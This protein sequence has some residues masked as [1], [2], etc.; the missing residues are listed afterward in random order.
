MSTNVRIGFVLA[1]TVLVGLAY[2]PAS[3]A[4]KKNNNSSSSD[5]KKDKDR[6]D[7]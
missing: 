4:D 2:S 5:D 6:K 1:L 7:P 3:F